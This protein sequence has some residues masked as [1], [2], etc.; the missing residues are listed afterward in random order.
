MAEVVGVGADDVF[1]LEGPGD[2]HVIPG[3]VKLLEVQAMPD[4]I[5][6]KL[7]DQL[8]P[9]AEAAIRAPLP[10]PAPCTPAMSNVF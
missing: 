9:A 4:G 3:W 8:G 6:L 10:R 2:I 1:T 7:L 5:M